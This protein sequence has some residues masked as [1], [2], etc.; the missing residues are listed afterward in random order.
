MIVKIKPE[1]KMIRPI[2]TITNNHKKTTSKITGKNSNIDRIIIRVIIVIKTIIELIIDTKRK[3]ARKIS[4]RILRIMQIITIRKAIKNKS[5]K[6]NANTSRKKIDLKKQNTM[7]RKSLIN[8][9]L[10]SNELSN[11]RFQYTIH[12]EYCDYNHNYEQAP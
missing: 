3:K 6:M 9:N 1:N 4:K 5:S 7:L 10:K 2:K 8:C 11:D 12:D